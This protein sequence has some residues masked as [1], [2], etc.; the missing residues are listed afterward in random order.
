M[1]KKLLSFLAPGLL[2]FSAIVGCSRAELEFDEQTQ[3]V[4]GGEVYPSRMF[5]T[6][7][8]SIK[9]N[10]S[11]VKELEANTDENGMVVSANVKS[12][13]TSLSKLGAIKMERIFPHAGRFEERTRAEGMHK[14]YYV[15]FDET[16]TLTK[17]S[18]DLKAVEGVEIVE[19]NPVITRHEYTKVAEV[20][21]D[22]MLPEIEQTADNPFDDPRLGSQWHYFNNGSRYYSEAGSDIN[23]F[24]VWKAGITGS[25]DVVVS[26]VDGGIDYAHEDLAD[27]M[28][29]NP[30]QSGDK[31][32][33]YN[34]VVGM[35][36]YNI[37][38]DEH[39]THVAGTVAAV[40]NNGKGVC[41]VAGGNFAEGVPGVRLMSCQIF[42]GET[43]GD[44]ARAIK[45][46]ADHGAVIS[47]NSWGY[48]YDPEHPITYTPQQDKD[49]IDYFIKYAGFDENGNQEGPMA[50]G[51][52]IFA[53]GNDDHYEGYPAS[54]EPAIAV[55]AIDAEYERAYYSNYGPWVDIAAPGG[56][57]YDNNEVWSTTP[58]NKYAAFQGTSMACPHVSGIAALVVSNLG[59]PGFTAADLKEILLRSYRSIDEYNPNY[60]GELGIGL[61]NTEAAV[62]G[63]EGEAP[64]Q[65]TEFSLESR[66]NNIDF[67]ITIPNDTDNGKPT[68]IKVYYKTSSFNADNY[69][70]AESKEFTVGTLTVGEVLEGT[71]SKLEFEKT[72]YVAVTAIDYVGQESILSEVK[73]V[74]TGGNNAPVIE[75][76]DPI[77]M[78]I[79]QAESPNIE[80]NIYDNDGHSLSYSL[81]PEVNGITLKIN[82]GSVS[83][84]T[85]N[86]KVMGEGNFKT[87]L[88]I[89][90]E[91]GLTASIDLDITV[92]GNSA[93]TLI[94]EFPNVVFKSDKEQSINLPVAEYITD[95]EDALTDLSYTVNISDKGIINAAYSNGNIM[96]S[97]LN[98][99]FVEVE[100]I[101]VDPIGESLNA[102]FQ[103]A[104]MAENI[105]ISTYPNPVVDY[106][107]I[108]SVEDMDA[109]VSIYSVAGTKVYSGNH[110]I[111]TFTPAQID[112]TTVGGGV[113][114]LV[115]KTADKEYKQTIVKQ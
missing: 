95:E 66:S 2:A 39:G 64:D 71:I 97:P 111:A 54:Y 100:V 19:Y 9:V 84:L 14:W 28:W 62:I 35:N 114:T 45:W 37:V 49:A 69:T 115:I 86:G 10:D 77:V 7:R 82:E 51:V 47:Q 56:D 76:N 74:V 65:V 40:N 33:G 42:A 34:F 16:I 50:G 98:P 91:Y 110:K 38:A 57:S 3:V 112:M 75:P 20:Q 93:P 15:Y 22:E 61:I 106:L 41:G 48:I 59:G 24:P 113:Y 4:Y 90:D 108:R 55:S 83:Y 43:G 8:V 1:L 102:K 6:G 92:E 17:A 73:T 11:L 67:D 101:A 46:G 63:G 5:Q 32:Y 70:T 72:Y 53:A 68:K 81:S 94:K 26:I 104:V 87:D 105:A 31:V 23:V 29:H 27:N 25:Q 79:K 30:A 78:T 80:L 13:T 107:Y 36:G 96:V 99:G 44:A 58:G 21:G 109:E 12:M 60:V 18:D 85:L 88:I 52:V 103:V 89:T